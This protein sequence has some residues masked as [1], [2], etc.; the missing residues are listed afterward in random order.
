M[1][2]ALKE[3]LFYIPAGDQWVPRPTHECGAVLSML[4]RPMEALRK[5]ARKTHPMDR[6]EYSLNYSGQ[7]QVRYLKATESLN[8][9]GILRKHG[10]L[11]F[12]MKFEAYNLTAKSNPSPRGINPPSDEYLVELGRYI[13]PIEK[14][15][16][17]ALRD[18]F[19]FTVVLK[20]YNNQTRGKI[21]SEY[22]REFD[23]PAGLAADASKFEQSVSAECI[24]VEKLVY[25]QYYSDGVVEK[26][27]GWQKQYKGKGSTT[28]GYLS[29]KIGGVRA[30]GMPNTALGNCLLSCLMA[31]RLFQILAISKYRFVCDG[32]DVHFIM[33]QRDVDRFRDYA[34]SYYHDL[35]FRM[36]M[37][38]TVN[39][40]EHIDFCQ[41]RPVKVNG[42]YMMV[43]NVINALSKDSLSKKPLDNR[44]IFERW[45]SAVGQGGL[46]MTGGI[47]IMQEFYMAYIRSSNGAAPLVGDPV[48]AD[49]D[50]GPKMFR[51]YEPV[52]E[53]TRYSFWLA[54]GI[55]PDHQRAIESY[56]REFSLEFGVNEEELV[57]YPKLPW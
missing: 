19:G 42:T 55:F 44:K 45:V 53:E 37:E 17:K 5:F 7:K 40:L 24:E 16:Y 52:A 36:K 18:L 35:G 25:S 3:R 34:K 9:T 33:E 8:R 46:S 49:Y 29:F 28:D 11:K 32:D 27:M 31:H 20:G 30:S 1:E 50:R 57:D 47:P 43:R 56:Y 15:I 22:W 14:R 4:S 23:N 2:R 48:Q 10:D 12:F 6:L 51:T 54:F 41:S 39:V 26:L 21:I 13:K 38:K